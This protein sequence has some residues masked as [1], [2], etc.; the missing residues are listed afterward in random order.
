V[1][2]QPQDLMWAF[3]LHDDGRDVYI[4]TPL[5]SA[6]DDNDFLCSRPATNSVASE[7]YL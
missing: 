2:G 4:V 3:S 7:E 5:I 6:H 1:N